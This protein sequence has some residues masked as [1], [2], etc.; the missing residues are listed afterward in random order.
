MIPEEI[1]KKIIA[2]LNEGEHYIVRIRLK[3]AHEKE[4]RDINT[5]LIAEGPEWVWLD[6]WYEGED[7]VHYVGFT[8]VNDVHIW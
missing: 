3:Y 4:F 2:E 1:E 7:V 8:A 5:L 6:D